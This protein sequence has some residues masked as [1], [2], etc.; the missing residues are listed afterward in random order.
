M[1]DK[2]YMDVYSTLN[3]SRT[4]INIPT[5]VKTTLDT[6]DLVPIKVLEMLP[7]DSISIDLSAVARELTLLNPPMDNAYLQFDVF[8]V[9]YR[10]IWDNTKRFFG[11]TDDIDIPDEITMPCAQFNLEDVVNVINVGTLGDYFGLPV[12]VSGY[13]EVE[14]VNYLPLRAYASIWNYWYRAPRIQNS[15]LFSKED[16]ITFGSLLEKGYASKPLKVGRFGD[17]FTSALPEP[18]FGGEV[19]F[20]SPYLPVHTTTDSSTLQFIRDYYKNYSGQTNGQL[21]KFM[22]T[23]A[24]SP[25]TNFT[26]NSATQSGASDILAGSTGTAGSSY[27]PLVFENLA[28]DTTSTPFHTIND[29]RLAIALAHYREA[30]GRFGNRYDESIKALFNVTTSNRTIQVPDYVGGYKHLLNVDQV[31]ATAQGTDYTVG[32]TGAMSNTGIANKSLCTTSV[33]EYGYIMILAHIRTDNTYSQGIPKL[34]SKKYRD[35]IYNPCFANIGNVPILNKEIYFQD[36]PE[37][38]N[39]VFGYQEAWYD[40]RYLP[41][42]NTAYMR[43][44]VENGFNSWTYQRVFN[45]LPVLNDD[46]IKQSAEEVDRT[47]AVTSRV[48]HQFKLDCFLNI[49]MT[50]VMPLYSVPGLE[51]I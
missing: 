19:N 44:N 39:Q 38:D 12:E 16:N 11:E 49:N 9:P 5:Q 25:G 28:A 1:A 22:T 29:L 48:T 27:T 30:L 15:V 26:L 36:N 46:F 43:G 34:F 6:G 21:V 37:V 23:N 33:D 14:V 42:I 8:W 3:T 18:E 2:R 51:K 13:D 50:R 47:I 7:G 10:I 4:K 20:I 45:G 40:M 32:S 41:N 17:L 24:V 31:L 35:E